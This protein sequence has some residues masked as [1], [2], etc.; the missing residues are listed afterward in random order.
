[1]RQAEP[2]CAE[3]FVVKAIARSRQG[4]LI[5]RGELTMYYSTLIAS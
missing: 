1:M 2:Q 4:E 5:S 3:N